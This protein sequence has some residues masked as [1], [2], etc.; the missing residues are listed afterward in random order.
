MIACLPMDRKEARLIKSF[1]RWTD[2]KGRQLKR[3]EREFL[4]CF[5]VN[6]KSPDKYQFL[7]LDTNQGIILLQNDRDY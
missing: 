1:S 7:F 3:N 6:Y 4:C 5:S 2:K